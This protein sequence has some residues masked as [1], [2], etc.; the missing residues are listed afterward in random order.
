MILLSRPYGGYNAGTI[1]QLSTNLEAQLIAQGFGTNSAG[2]VTSG[3][4]S[5]SLPSGRVGVAAAGTSVVVTN[6][7]IT[8]ESKFSVFLSNAAA[9]T[10]ATFVSRITP[11][12]GAVTFTLNAAAT[13]AV[14]LDWAIVG[15]FGGLTNT[16]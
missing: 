3:S 1:V 14:A 2:P 7:T 4:V 13:A 6:P 10:T 9:D 8:T 5:T 15:P 16:P 12:N 11:V